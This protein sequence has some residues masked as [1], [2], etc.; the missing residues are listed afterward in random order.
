M[1]PRRDRAGR[2]RCGRVLELWSGL[3]I[4]AGASPA[5]AAGEVRDRHAG[6]FPRWPTRC[7]RCPASA[8][9]LPRRSPRSP[10][11]PR[12]PFSKATRSGCSRDTPA[13]KASPGTTSL[14]PRCGNARKNACRIPASKPIAGIDGPRR[15]AVHALLATLRA[16]SGDR[17][18]GRSRS[19][20]G[21]R[22]PGAAT[23]SRASAEAMQRTAD[24]ARR[25]RAA[26]AG[27]RAAS[28]RD[29][30]ACRKP[31]SASMPQGLS[32]ALRRGGQRLTG[33]RAHRVGFT[34]YRLTLF[35]NP[36]RQSTGP[37]SSTS[38]K[39][40][41]N[42]DGCPIEQAASG[43]LPSPIKK[44]LVARSLAR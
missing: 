20:S 36:A 8:A 10:P 28:G 30:G 19:G 32:R 16:V 34:H 18:S 42:F 4:T 39:C 24:R 23:A 22:V 11:E 21:R 40:S 5:P 17:P 14:Q 44:L 38:P 6:V 12:P 2:C 43:A 33:A 3:V 1:L 27:P 26:R 35:H 9:R 41:P 7:R 31:M 37:W 15:D 13:L 25:L 29:C